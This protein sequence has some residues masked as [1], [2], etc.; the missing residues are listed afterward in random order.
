MDYSTILE[1]Y[2]FS[3]YQSIGIYKPDQLDVETIAARLGV[4]LEYDD[5]SSKSFELGE[6][7]F[8]V[9][10]NQFIPQQQWQDFGHEL[11]HLLR[12]CGNQTVLP[13]SFREMQEWQANNFAQHF[14]IPTFMLEK[15]MFPWRK[16]E[17]IY[18]IAQVFHVE[19]TFAAERL[20]RWLRQKE[21][22]YFYEKMGEY[23]K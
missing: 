12:H 15:M 4:V 17:V 13:S 1:D 18:T 23:Q 21:S 14:C 8:I 6:I 19:F 22:L 16:Q 10:N 11:G 5:K 20:E 2:I 3:L 9:L 7:P